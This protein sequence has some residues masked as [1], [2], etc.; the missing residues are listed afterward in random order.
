MKAFKKKFYDETFWEKTERKLKQWVNS[1]KLIKINF[2]SFKLKSNLRFI[3]ICMSYYKFKYF[4][5]LGI[6]F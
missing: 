6:N 1:K 2:L 4:L 3:Y 5:H